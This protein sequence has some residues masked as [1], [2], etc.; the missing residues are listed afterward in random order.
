MG[1]SNHGGLQVERASTIA[2]GS[3]HPVCDCKMTYCYSWIYH[4][5]CRIYGFI[6]LCFSPFDGNSD[7]A[8]LLCRCCKCNKKSVV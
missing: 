4:H 5:L 8:E 2:S 6:W 1:E 7:Q 3:I